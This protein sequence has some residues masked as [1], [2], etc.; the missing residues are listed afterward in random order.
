VW[1]KNVEATSTVTNDDIIIFGSVNSNCSSWIS[2]D[3]T[4][5]QLLKRRLDKLRTFGKVNPLLF[6][7]FQVPDAN[8]LVTRTWN[9]PLVAVC[10]NDQIN[11]STSFCNFTIYNEFNLFLKNAQQVTSWVCP[12][13]VH[14]SL[15]VFASQTLSVLSSE[16]ETISLPSWE[17]FTCRTQFVWPELA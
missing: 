1:R 3:K 11:T 6:T 9:K 10:R 17:Y 4:I 7:R 5:T 12:I 8:A 16:T 14:C 2:S 15:K 13:R